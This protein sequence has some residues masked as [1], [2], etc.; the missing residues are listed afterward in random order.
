MYVH[1]SV[2]LQVVNQVISLTD[3]YE[4][5]QNSNHVVVSDF[6]KFKS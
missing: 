6:T 5:I 4:I 2:N 3:S 1:E